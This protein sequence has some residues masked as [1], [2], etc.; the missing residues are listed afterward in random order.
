[1]IRKTFF[2]QLIKHGL[3]NNYHWVIGRAMSLYNSWFIT[4]AI[5]RKEEPIDLTKRYIESKTTC[6]LE[7]FSGESEINRNISID[8]SFYSK[9]KFQQLLIDT[10]NTIEKQWKTRILYESTPRGNIIMYYDVYKQGF[11]YYSDVTSIPYS[12]LNSVAMKY[13]LIY[14]CR[15]FFMDNQI[16]PPD[17]PSP[18]IKIHFE[19]ENPKGQERKKV[20]INTGGQ[21]AKFKNYSI[22][23]NLDKNKAPEKQYNKNR[24]I[25]LGKTVNFQFIQ[26]KPKKNMG[27][28]TSKFT[29][30]LLNENNVQKL[31]MS[32]SDYKKK[33]VDTA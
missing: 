5:C 6:F 10:D 18:L 2:F 8:E 19:E 17:S 30:M 14:N 27:G 3:Y 21:F 12:V 29:E 11:S 22:S 1:M 15:D 16:T 28:F 4:P 31:V 32:Y 24:F 26:V 13:V 20:S 7:T 23:N 9:K 33:Q 25:N